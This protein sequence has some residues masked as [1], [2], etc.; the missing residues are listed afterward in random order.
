MFTIIE[1]VLSIIFG[2]LV[3]VAYG[4][5]LFEFMEMKIHKILI[6]LFSIPII[7][8][9]SQPALLLTQIILQYA[10]EYGY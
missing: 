3:G 10:R 8:L 9:L 5:V 7:W 2:G 1:Y 4:Y 6:V